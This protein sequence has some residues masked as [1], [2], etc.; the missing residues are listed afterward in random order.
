MEEAEQSV[1]L[2]HG[3]IVTGGYALMVRDLTFDKSKRSA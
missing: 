3:I 1:A 2:V